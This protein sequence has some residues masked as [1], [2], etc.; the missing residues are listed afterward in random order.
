[1]AAARTFPDGFLWGTA[2]AAYQVEGAVAEDGRGASIWD[3][4]AHTP[5][6]IADGTNADVAVDHYHRYREDVRLMAELGANA[7]RFS[8]AWPRVFPEGTGK[9]NP[10]G[11]DFYRRLVDELLANGIEPFA[12]LYHW[13]LPQSLQQRHGGW[14]SRETPQAFADY[15]G[16]VAG[17]LSDRV[18]NFFTINEFS[19]FV[20]MGHGSGRLAPGLRLAPA[21]LNQVRHHAVLG[22]GLA[23]QAIRANASAGVRVGPAEQVIT[24]IPVIETPEHIRA[25]AVA[26]R[27]LNA[28]YLTVM[29]EGKYTDGFLY[30]QGRDAPRFTDDDLKA[31]SSP[32]DFVG[33]NIY[34]AHHIVRAA[35]TSLGFAMVPYQSV[36]PRVAWPGGALSLRLTPESMYWGTRLLADLW[37][38]GDIYITESGGPFT[39]E[40]GAVGTQPDIDGME[41]DSDRIV[42]L[43][44]YLTQLQR[45]TDEGVPVRGYFHW[46]TMDNFEWT[47]GLRPRFGLYRVDYETQRRTPKLSAQYFRACA[48]SNAVL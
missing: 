38:V 5:G 11:L 7:Y 3:V 37:H 32:L 45:A 8:I 30:E 25:A 21:Q 29:L 15:A 22:H 34:A 35:D 48:Q 10:K 33:T 31:I 24:A 20:E 2:T 39:H 28:G 4:F 42:W 27:E 19:S 43:R 18:R 23:V 44:A 6:A 40:P 9:P 47:L 1:M 17:R 41:N 13:D 26:T 12:T 46:S 16:Y 14:Q 36:H